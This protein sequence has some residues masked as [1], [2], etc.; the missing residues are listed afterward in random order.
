MAAKELENS[1]G[2]VAPMGEV[3]L[4]MTASHTAPPLAVTDMKG[5]L[6]AMRNR[7]LRASSARRLVLEALFAAER[8]VSAEELAGGLGG[9]VTP[10][11]QASVYRNLETLEEVGLIRHFHLGHGPGLY[12]PAGT[13]EREYLVC[14]SC[15]TVT[16]V[17]SHEMEPVRALIEQRFGY[18]AHFGHFPILGLC[19]ECARDRAG[20]STPDRRPEHD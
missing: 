20:D 1:P 11:D 5:A 9:R 3:E 19:A 12:A 16:A 10:S 14:D 8:P 18:E 4:T 13:G 15:R 7:G 17:D 6:A 2:R